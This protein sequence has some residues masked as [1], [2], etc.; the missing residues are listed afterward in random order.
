MIIEHV[1]TCGGVWGL[2]YISTQSNDNGLVEI[3]HDEIS[4]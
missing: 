2:R 4:Y 1:L 3:K